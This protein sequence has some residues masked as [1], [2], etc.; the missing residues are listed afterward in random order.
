MFN[1]VHAEARERLDIS[2]AMVERVNILVKSFDM[3][4][5]VG[6]IE[7][8]LPIERNPEECKDECWKNYTKA[9]IDRTDAGFMTSVFLETKKIVLSLSGCGGDEYAGFLIVNG[10]ISN[11]W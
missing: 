7:V 5:P 3:D 10:L 8:K 1:R 6:K 2:V 4:E 9:K 11:S